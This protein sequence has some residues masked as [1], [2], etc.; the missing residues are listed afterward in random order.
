MDQ[1]DI[2]KIIKTRFPGD[3]EKLVYCVHC[4]NPF[5]EIP[6]TENE[7]LSAMGFSQASNADLRTRELLYRALPDLFG[8]E[9]GVKKQP[10]RCGQCERWRGEAARPGTT[11][12]AFSDGTSVICCPHCL[13]PIHRGEGPYTPEGYRAEL[14][15]RATGGAF[16]IMPDL[17]EGAPLAPED[18]MEPHIEPPVMAGEW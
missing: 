2:R 5:L 14:L 3:G 10:H 12:A 18:N 8:D 16:S 7:R 15:R 4:L 11:N 6:G 17:F 13:M 9:E 1:D